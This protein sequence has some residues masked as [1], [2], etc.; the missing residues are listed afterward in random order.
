MDQEKTDRIVTKDN[1]VELQD[2]DAWD[3]LG[4]SFPTWR[5]WQILCV[6]FLIQVSINS[7]ASMYANAVTG[8][9]EKFGVTKQTAR[10]PQLLFLVAYGFGCELWA[11]W[12]EEYGRW[13]IQQLSLFLVNM[14]QIPC[15]LSKNYGTYVICRFLGGLSTA[16]GSVTLGV[17]A[18]M[19]EPDEQEY[20]VA[21]LV[22]S[23][24]GGSVIGT[25][26]GGFVE[27]YLSLPWVFWMQ[28]ILGGFVQL[29]HLVCNPETRST[30][31][32]DREARR[33][34]K[35]GEDPNCYGPNEIRTKRMSFKEFRTIFW[36]PFYMF[37]TEPI[38]LWLSLLSGF[39]DA[40]IFTFLQ[41][42]Q[43]VYEQWGFGT[44]GV[45]LAFLPLLIGY[46]LSYL[47]YLP[48]IRHFRAKRRKDPN[49][50]KPEA[51]LWWLLFLAPLETIGLFGFA[52]T[53]LGPD[54]GIPWIAT[55]IFSCMVGIANYAIYQSSIDYQTAAYGPYAAS[56]TGGNDLARDFLAGIAALYSTPM[57]TK[58]PGRPLEYASTILACMAIL[59]TIPVYI[60]Y[61]KGPEIREKSKF[62]QS[63]DKSREASKEKR[64]KSG[65]GR[66]DVIEEK[67]RK[68]SV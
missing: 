49:S 36:R 57:Y 10:V 35:T 39:S 31:L 12:S 3:K 26:I 23:S 60:V 34:R 56:A 16:G 33:R 51:R 53:S 41:S 62:A 25:L 37:F 24:V 22:L 58:I 29:V 44:I 47:S 6:V 61:K 21:F 42:F 30:I 18:D 5:K 48:S 2:S 11:P 32:L 66:K 14:F 54:Y 7:N 64:R 1:R 52:W 50:V 27:A 43:P 20:A 13:P 46:I 9:H 15:A 63:L 17:L 4:Y 19:W 8:I 65:V 40:L 28:L 45:H 68:D 38:V 59:V 55:M 67:W